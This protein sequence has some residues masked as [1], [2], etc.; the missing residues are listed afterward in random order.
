MRSMEECSHC[1]QEIVAPHVLERPFNRIE[2]T[3][4]R[5][6]FVIVLVVELI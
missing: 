6:A 1:H 3:V 5:G 4:Y 2:L